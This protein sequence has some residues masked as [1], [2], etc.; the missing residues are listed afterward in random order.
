M[1]KYLVVFFVLL[2]FLFFR[3]DPIPIN[4]D[5]FWVFN[6][7][8]DIVENP[9]YYSLS[10][11]GYR[12]M[13]K[14]IY[15]PFFWAE[16]FDVDKL[17]VIATF[18]TALFSTGLAFLTYKFFSRLWGEMTG[19]IAAFLIGTSNAM[20]YTTWYWSSTHL[21][22]GT[23]FFLAAVHAHYF[24][25]KKFFG[26]SILAGLAMFTRETFAIPVVL[27]TAYMLLHYKE[28]KKYYVLLP[29]ILFS[30]YTILNKIFLGAFINPTFAGKVQFGI[31]NLTSST[32]A[33]HLSQTFLL[34]LFGFLL[35]L[36]LYNTFKKGI[37]I[38]H[39]ILI[40]WLIGHVVTLLMTANADK[41][42]LIPILPLIFAFGA[43]QT[44]ELLAGFEKKTETLTI[45]VLVI[46][47]AVFLSRQA[48]FIFSPATWTFLLHFLIYVT[49]LFALLLLLKP[50]LKTMLASI[51]F[52]LMIASS[53][54]QLSMTYSF[55]V[56][57]YD[58]TTTPNAAVAWL[59][60]NS[61]QN[62]MVV[63]NKPNSITTPDV[64][65]FTAFGRADITSKHIIEA[66]NIT[67]N[68]YL[69]STPDSKM[70]KDE[71]GA[72]AKELGLK[73]VKTFGKEKK[74]YP[75]LKISSSAEKRW[76][77]LFTTGKLFSVE[78]SQG[79]AVSIYQHNKP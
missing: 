24:S 73:T 4:S 66:E 12:I 78:E 55:F 39:P 22:I 31:E 44:K 30:A 23:F 58:W 54:I 16:E 19:I 7:V 70:E 60:K 42:Y 5:D 51:F 21:I 27:I 63:T 76:Q 67:T 49:L 57:Q 37:I 71:T 28:K 41:R 43:Y 68:A 20:Y 32:Y 2:F 38:S 36:F 69:W 74:K 64:Y 45:I 59:A 29:L 3:P 10:G 13:H 75:L 40:L 47:H 62:S 6:I 79:Y 53:I 26:W 34:P 65:W 46:W 8:R 15:L 25:K 1:Q 18:I 33:N 61:P 17:A 56:Y 48:L 72:K 35:L 52:V 14:L 11:S 50:S 9:S 77:Q